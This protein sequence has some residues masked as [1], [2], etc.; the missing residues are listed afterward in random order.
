MHRISL[1]A[2]LSTG[3]F[4][5]P[6]DMSAVA[7][8]HAGPLI[9]KY[10][11]VEFHFENEALWL[12]HIDSFTGEDFAPSGGRRLELDPWFVSDGAPLR[13]IAE[14]LSVAGLGPRTVVEPHFDRILIVLPAGI[15]LGFSGTDPA[16]AALAFISCVRQPTDLEGR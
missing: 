13:T 16:Q 10:G 1:R 12:I 7:K 15:E 2:F 8:K 6:E 11:D 3:T 9:W 5:V 4:G 14:E